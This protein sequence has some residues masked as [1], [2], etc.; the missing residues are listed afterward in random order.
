MLIIIGAPTALHRK[1]S[2]QENLVRVWPPQAVCG[3]VWNPAPMP[4][5]LAAPFSCRFTMIDRTLS[6]AVCGEFVSSYSEAAQR[7][8]LSRVFIGGFCQVRVNP[9]DAKSAI[10]LLQQPS[11][12]KLKV[13]AR[14]KVMQPQANNLIWAE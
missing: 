14:T 3:P 8:P 10:T 4:N 1:G 6:S 11:N 13:Q 9:V 5:M 7:V 12:N 2:M